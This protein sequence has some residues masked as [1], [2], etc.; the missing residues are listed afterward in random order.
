M[1]IFNILKIKIVKF[2]FGLD[3]LTDTVVKVSTF[4]TLL[5]NN[6][7]LIRHPYKLQF[8]IR[9][10]FLQIHGNLLTYINGIY[11]LNFE[12][13]FTVLLLSLKSQ[14]LKELLKGLPH[15][16]PL[17]VLRVSKRPPIISAQLWNFFYTNLHVLPSSHTTLNM[18]YSLP[19]M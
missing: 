14:K 19:F 7:F 13:N 8:F 16:T 17:I 12:V 3:R 9:Y 4:A 10:F 1:Q 15:W 5:E 18:Y 2:L 11:H 6:I